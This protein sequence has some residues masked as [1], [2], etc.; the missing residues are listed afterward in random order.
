MEG[1]TKDETKKVRAE[2]YGACMCEKRI[3]SCCSKKSIE[4]KERQKERTSK[5][6]SLTREK[7][8][9]LLT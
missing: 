9:F 4:T 6:V 7:R 3:F 8:R 1:G 2:Q 5:D